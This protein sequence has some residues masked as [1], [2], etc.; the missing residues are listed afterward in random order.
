MKNKWV[1]IV[2]AAALFTACSKKRPIGEDAYTTLFYKQTFCADPWSTGATDSATL[3]NVA[4]YLN[5]QGLYVAGLNIKQETAPEI[6]SACGCK[7]GKFIYAT[8]LN[9]TTLKEQYLRIGFSS[10]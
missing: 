8:T 7:T 2:V 9:S 1:F 6:C 4:A 3:V 5:T 10:K